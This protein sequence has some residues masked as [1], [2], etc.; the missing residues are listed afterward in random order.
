MLT[1]IMMSFGSQTKNL[2]PVVIRVLF[3]RVPMRSKPTDRGELVSIVYSIRTFLGQTGLEQERLD[4]TRI[5]PMNTNAPRWPRD[6][7]VADSLMRHLILP[8]VPRAPFAR[9]SP[10]HP[11]PP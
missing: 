10:A 6:D 1:D 7:S 2:F 11:D 4:G 5:K 9:S 3:C 8:A